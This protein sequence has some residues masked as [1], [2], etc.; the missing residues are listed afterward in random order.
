[1]SPL[2]SSSDTPTQ[3]ILTAHIELCPTSLTIAVSR[4]RGNRT[5]EA[6]QDGWEISH[7]KMQQ[8]SKFPVCSFCSFAHSLPLYQ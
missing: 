6:H 3:E 8:H 1:M 2:D 5:V 7:L 4:D